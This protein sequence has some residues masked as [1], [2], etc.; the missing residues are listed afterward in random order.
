MGT[1]LFLTAVWEMAF[2]HLSDT[3]TGLAVVV[4][5]AL[6]MAGMW[7]SP[8]MRLARA[9]PFESAPSLFS[10]PPPVWRN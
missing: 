8:T 10:E 6:V 5:L 1:V 4:G 7:Y 9:V 2:G 3:K